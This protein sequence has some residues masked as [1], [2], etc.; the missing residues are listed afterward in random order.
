MSLAFGADRFVGELRPPPD[1][2]GG[3]QLEQLAGVDRAAA[4]LGVDDT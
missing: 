1:D 4:Q 3:Q 2:D